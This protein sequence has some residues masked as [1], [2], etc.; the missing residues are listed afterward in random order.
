VS[1][2][3]DFFG[4][5]V[6]GGDFD[7]NGKDDLAISVPGDDPGVV[8]DAG[9]VYVVPGAVSGLTANGSRF[10]G[11]DIPGVVD[12][13]G[14]GDRFGWALTTGDFNGDRRDDLAVGVPF[15]DIGSTSS[16]G[17]VHIFFGSAGGITT[18][19]NTVLT[20]G[21]VFG[22]DTNVQ[23]GNAFG[24]ALAAADFNADG[25]ADLA[26][27]APFQDFFNDPDCGE[28]DVIYGSSGGLARRAG[29]G[30]QSWHQSF[31]GITT[32]ISDAE[33]HDQFGQTLTAWNFGRDFHSIR[34]T[35]RT[36]DLAVGV[37]FED[38]FSHVDHITPEVNA[39]AVNVIYGSPGGL[40]E[41]NNQFWYEDSDGVP[42]DAES[43]DFFGMAAY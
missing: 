26:V 8:T 40:T 13:A 6:A 42:G 39:G 14:S 24:F 25:F 2:D 16:A 33:P 35:I 15:D 17:S 3:G 31:A 21:I 10:L 27:G 5:A 30:S 1:L 7:G 36:A 9:G 23:T 43:N 28:V 22:D 11:R 41:A 18:S 19:G 37:P 4:Q 38:V 29:P 34:G 32:L 20:Q 12:V